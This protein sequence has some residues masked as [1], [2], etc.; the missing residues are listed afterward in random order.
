MGDVSIKPDEE[1][2]SLGRYNA[3]EEDGLVVIV[4]AGWSAQ[5]R[6]D[7]SADNSGCWGDDQHAQELLELYGFSEAECRKE[8][9]KLVAEHWAMV[10]ALATLLLEEETVS[11][12]DID[13]VCVSVE[14]GGDWQ[15]DLAEYRA[16]K[17][18][19]A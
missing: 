1:E 17:G 5:R 6:F 9:D 4:Y 16:L 2:S 13:M 14:E 18:G 11:A 7:P 3:C 19:A 12:D 15:R 8:A 10:E